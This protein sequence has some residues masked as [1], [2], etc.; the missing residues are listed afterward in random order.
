MMRE[1]IALRQRQKRILTPW[2]RLWFKSIRLERFSF[3]VIP[4]EVEGSHG[5]P[6]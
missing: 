4:T 3:L 1:T 5:T 2:T 6:Y